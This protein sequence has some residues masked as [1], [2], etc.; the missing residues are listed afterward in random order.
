MGPLCYGEG[1]AR[2][3]LQ[4]VQADVGEEGLQG[5]GAALVRDAQ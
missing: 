3:H 5:A 4:L 2:A 1:G